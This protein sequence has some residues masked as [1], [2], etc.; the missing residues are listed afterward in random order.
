MCRVPQLWLGGLEFE[1]LSLGLGLLE[2]GGLEL[3]LGGL[4][5]TWFK[6]VLGF[7]EVG[8]GCVE[9]GWIESVGWI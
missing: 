6:I 1:G 2:L 7:V 4:G 8:V 9:V 5:L 3:W